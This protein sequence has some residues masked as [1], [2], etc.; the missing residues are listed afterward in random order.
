MNID[1]L[2]DILLNEQPSI[3]IKENEHDIF[4]LIPELK[5]SVGFNQNNIWH[6]Y[7]VYEHILHVV[8]NVSSNIILRLTALFHDIG[9]PFVYTEDENKVGHFYGHWDK[10]NEIFN[11]FANKYNLD[12]DLVDIVSKLITYHDIRI[13]KLSD[14]ELFELANKFG[15]DGIKILFEIKRSDLLSQNPKFHNL[16]DDYNKDEE[17]LLKLIR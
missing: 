12:K 13:N 14:E 17:K 7:D 5:E 16:L 11:A 1:K 2:F 15:K 9:K 4:N 8:D 6:I 10:S 3:Y